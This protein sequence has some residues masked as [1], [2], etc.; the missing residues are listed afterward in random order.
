MVVVPLAASGNE[1]E[2]SSKGGRDSDSTYWIRVAA[3]GSLATSGVLL[4]AGK[5]RAGLIAAAAGAALTVLDQQETVRNW[6]SHL[7]GYL[8]EVQTI[9]TRAQG[10][11][12]ELSAQGERLRNILSR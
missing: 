9:L 10:A 3:A 2:A 8:E 11:V 5:R 12:D 6:W 7:P 1:P 4:M